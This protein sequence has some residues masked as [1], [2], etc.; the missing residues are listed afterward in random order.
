M[1]KDFDD[2]ANSEA[3]VCVTRSKVQSAL[4]R[5]SIREEIQQQRQCS[6]RILLQ[7]DERKIWSE[8][9]SITT[10]MK[11]QCQSDEMIG[12]H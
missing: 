9:C 3:S 10:W 12:P 11:D 8:F 7:M 6:I 4:K 2:E 5:G 1:R